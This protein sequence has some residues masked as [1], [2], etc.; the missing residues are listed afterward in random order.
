MAITVNYTVFDGLLHASLSY[1][2]S[3]LAQMRK[4][5]ARRK[6]YKESY[7]ALSQLSE[8]GLMDLGCHA[9]ASN[10]AQWR[11][12]M[13][14]SMRTVELDRTGD[15]RIHLWLGKLSSLARGAYQAIML[16]RMISV[17]SQMSDMQLEKIGI[18]RSEIVDHATKL[19]E[20]S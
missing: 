5:R 1:V 3:K 19:V 11:W 17:L 14:S 4:S 12:P 15:P 13:A 16:A 8:R 20:A 9:P 2:H 7:H 10:L 18:S 6:V